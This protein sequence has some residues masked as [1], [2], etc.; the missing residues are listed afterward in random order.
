MMNPMVRRM[1]KMSYA[2]HNDNQQVE[3]ALS[4]CKGVYQRNVILGIESLSG[5]TLKGKAKNYSGRYARSRDN[6]LDRMKKA[7]VKFEEVCGDHNKRI[8]VIG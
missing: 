1:N 6:L 8:L 7:G 5:S 2:I 4:L 3:K